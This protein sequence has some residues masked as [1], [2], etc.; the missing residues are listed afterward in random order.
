[1]DVVINGITFVETS[2]APLANIPVEVNWFIRAYCIGCTSYRVA[3]GKTDSAGKFNFNTTIASTFF[4]DYYLSV[5]VPTD[6]NYITAPNVGGVN[7]DEKRFSDF[8]INALQNLKF[9]FYPKTF[10]TIRLHRVLSDNFDY[11]SVSHH[12][13]NAV[14]YEDFI[15]AGP[16]FAIDTTLRVPTS[17]NIYTTI[18]W[19]KTITG[20][21]SNEQTDSLI[22]TDNGTNVF[23]INY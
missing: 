6:T 1:M 14:D 16:R 4:K 15:I 8:N 3:S 11:F 2:G 20:G 13:T 12:F 7:F 5:R 19:G 18:V 10:L 21:Q 9:G 22:C 17:A 23:D